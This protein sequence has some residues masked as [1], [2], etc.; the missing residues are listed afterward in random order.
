MNNFLDKNT[1]EDYWTQRYEQGATGWDIGEASC[2]LVAYIDQLTNKSLR[3]LLPGGGNAHEAYELYRRGFVNTF[4]V[5]ISAYPLDNFRRQYPDFPQAQLLHQNFFA[6]QSTYDL[7]LEQTFFCALLP[8]LRPHYA[9]QMHQLLADDGKLVGVLFDA[10]L[11]KDHPPFGGNRDEY[12]PVLSPYF[13][14][15]TFE[16]CYNSISPRQGKELF[17]QLHKKLS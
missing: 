15:Q 1:T 8:E 7:I 16:R 2:P 9:Q 4:V 14:A 3:I 6:H 13:R 17:I 10:P 11:N 12:W 5:D